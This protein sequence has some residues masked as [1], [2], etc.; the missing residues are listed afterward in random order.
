MYVVVVD[1]LLLVNDG[2]CELAF[3]EH[4]E[5]F[6]D[7]SLLGEFLGLLGH[8][9][10]LD[11]EEGF[12]HGLTF[13]TAADLAVLNMIKGFMPFGAAYRIG[14]YNVSVKY[15]KL[16]AHAAHVA[17]D[18]HVRSYL[19]RST[20]MQ[21]DPFGFRLMPVARQR[22]VSPQSSRNRDLYLDR[23]LKDLARVDQLDSSITE[24][25]GQD[26]PLGAES[27]VSLSPAR[28]PVEVK[29]KE[30]KPQLVWA[31]GRW[32][33]NSKKSSKEPA[34]SV[35]RFAVNLV[36]PKN[37]TTNTGFSLHHL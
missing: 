5:A 3:T 28:Q 29:E 33:A 14:G 32:P 19:K 2:G 16:A 15:P 10:G 7:Q 13:P 23:A 18:P 1:E 24:A 36:S 21:S 17:K 31:R 34:V 25:M 6:S 4:V 12:V 26:V 30:V 35:M 9:V 8:R 22:S 11:E 27:Q 37:T 20:T